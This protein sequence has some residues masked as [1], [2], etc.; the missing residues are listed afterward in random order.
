[1]DASV[2]VRAG[3]RPEEATQPVTS[4]HLGRGFAWAAGARTGAYAAALVSGPLLARMLTPE[5][6]G[7]YFL[8]MTVATVGSMLALM[9]LSGV[10]LREVSAAVGVGRPD[11]ARSAIVATVLLACAGAALTAGLLVS[12]AGHLLAA[13]V[14]HSPRLDGLMPLVAAW[15][16]LL[17]AGILATNIW[18]GLGNVRL[19]VALGDFGPKAVFAIGVAVLWLAGRHTDVSTVLWLWVGVLAVLLAAWTI[20][21][22]RRVASFP[23]GPR[24]PHRALA[25]AG[26]AIL[27][28]G[29]MWQ[30]MDQIDLVILANAAPRHDVALYGAAARISLL[31]S[32][33]LLM[34]EFVVA[35][36]VG[37]LNARGE[38]DQLQSVLRRAATIAMV[39]T[40]LATIAVLA[41]GRWILDGL[42]GSYYGQAW[43]VLAVLAVGD[44]AFVVTGSCGLALWMTGR[45]RLTATVATGFAVVTLGAAVATAH[46]F[47]MLGLAITMAL[48]IASQN[49]V[50][51]VLARRRL[52]VWTHSYL[53]PRGIVAAVASVVRTAPA[54]PM[55]GIRTSESVGP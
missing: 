23:A 46:A 53:H 26:V 48:G 6:L 15:T 25:G 31:L 47:G 5:A 10:A 44:L 49:V 37:A 51:L 29:L 33:P 16:V 52:G 45:Q 11:R 54:A 32:V 7:D 43:P 40:A 21:V 30:A 39:P 36:L 4:I 17:M 2:A 42:Y 27:L 50:L 14:L 3:A 20:V 28:T 24:I 55:A 19:A 34:V 18:R 1:M 12:P 8:A 22:S 13:D 35:P 38:T 41:A 9:G